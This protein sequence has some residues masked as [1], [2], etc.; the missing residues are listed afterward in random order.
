MPNSFD[1]VGGRDPRGPRQ[2]AIIPQATVSAAEIVAPMRSIAAA[3][4]TLGSTV[5]GMGEKLANATSRQDGD[6]GAAAVTRDADGSIQYQQRPLELTQGDKMFNTAA[7]Q[8]ALAMFQTDAQKGFSDLAR[9]NQLDPQAFETSGRAFVRELTGRL[10][11]ELRPMGEQFAQQ[12]LTQH[13]THIADAK[14]KVDTANEKT[15]L[16][17][18]VEQGV[19]DLM[20]LAKT[21]GE[22]TPEFHQ[23]AANVRDLY[24][25]LSANP[26]FGVP[27]EKMEIDLARIGDMARG[28]AI[29]GTVDRVF[30]EGGAVAARNYVREKIADDTTSKLGEAERAKLVSMADARISFKEGQRKEQVEINRKSVSAIKD[31]WQGGRSVPDNMVDDV[32]AKATALGDQESVAELTIRRALFGTAGVGGPDLQRT[33]AERRAAG[34]GTPAGVTAKASPV[35]ISAIQTAAA[36]YGVS[37]TLLNRI[38]HV[39]SRFDPNAYNPSGATG[40][41]QFMPGTWKQYGNG[42]NARDPVANADAAARLLIANRDQLATSIGRA[43]TEGEIYLA[44]Q[45]GAAGAAK[46]LKNPDKPAVDVVGR[47]AV[48]QNGGTADMTAGQF[49]QLWIG[50]FDKGPGVAVVAGGGY[51]PKPSAA[52]DLARNPYTMPAYLRAV[53]DDGKL[54]ASAASTIADGVIA[55][56]RQGQLPNAD[57]LAIVMQEAQHSPAL[58]EKR[59]TLLQQLAGYDQAQGDLSQPTAAGAALVA[60]AKAQAQGGSIMVQKIAEARETFVKQGEAAMKASPWDEAVRRGWGNAPAPLS[61]ANPGAA[62][63]AVSSREDLAVSVATRT[64]EAAKSIIAPAEVETFK[65]GMAGAPP[66]AI[67]AFF[68]TLMSARPE[69]LDATMSDSNVVESLKGLAR[70][71]DPQRYKAVN[72]G[73]SALKNRDPQK[74]ADAFGQDTLKTVQE[75]EV[76][77]QFTTDD[78]LKKRLSERTDPAAEPVIKRWKSDADKETAGLDLKDVAKLSKGLLDFGDKAPEGGPAAAAMMGDYAALVRDSVVAA[79]GDVEAAKKMAA[80]RFGTIYSISPTN[81]G[82]V[83]KFAPE[84]FLRDE[85]GKPLTINGSFDWVREQLQ[86][87]LRTVARPEDT[88]EFRLDQQTLVGAASPPVVKYQ[89][90]PYA[91]TQAAIARG[92]APAYRLVYQDPR[93]AEWHDTFWQPDVERAKA[94]EMDRLRA[95]EAG[96]RSGRDA[97]D[98]DIRRRAGSQIPAFGP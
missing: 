37:E 53:A 50:K 93:T 69:V 52:P 25:A 38:A 87:D 45:Q 78:A 23:A 35:V 96:Q 76:A 32:L 18:R 81:N 24:G 31:Q 30:Q 9:T 97:I 14:V 65:A 22:G 15:A 88:N 46:L 60:Q 82:R 21:G 26:K 71:D 64:G 62:V 85:K 66:A 44:H 39:E 73:L 72:G 41:F 33:D 27:K 43:P 29:V 86:S 61:F 83:M 91:G 89:L 20:T 2:L 54:L 8:G 77:G 16:T 59:D 57:N 84:K 6:A 19:T 79:R 49:A 63:Q 17:A 28:E 90:V 34:L 13:L 5:E 67:S 70:T 7:R 55:G 92:V 3:W 1:S 68:N 40:L 94:A 36:K 98:A 42:Q 4:G 12:Q 58:A 51:A 56:L 95:A 80:E 10:P 47:A 48:M 74:F 75:Y 11:K